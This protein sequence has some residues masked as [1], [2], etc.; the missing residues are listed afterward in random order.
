MKIKII[1][2]LII[3]DF[4]YSDNL[5]WF[6]SIWWGPS[7]IRRSQKLVKLLLLF[8]IKNAVN[9]VIDFE[10]KYNIYLISV[11]HNEDG[12]QQDYQVYAMLHN[13]DFNQK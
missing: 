9:C 2:T 12:C 1:C 10:D 6:L 7:A 8:Q 4:I 5:G 3:V 13:V 11:S